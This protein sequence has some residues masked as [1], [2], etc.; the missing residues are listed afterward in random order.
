MLLKVLSTDLRA[1]LVET[2]S[3]MD[4]SSAVLNKLFLFLMPISS[5]RPGEGETPFLFL[6][7]ILIC[8]IA[9]H[10]ILQHGWMDG[11][12]WDGAV[13][14]IFPCVTYELKSE[15]PHLIAKNQT[16]L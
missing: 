12:I 3:D 5:E 6:G 1:D 2:F 15:S 8:N 16:E 9:H 10:S 4:F 11:W 14:R 7:P 13:R